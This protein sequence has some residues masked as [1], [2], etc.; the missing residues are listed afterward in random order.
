MKSAHRITLIALA[1]SAALGAGGAA[2]SVFASKPAAAPEVRPALTVNV[3]APQTM[4]LPSR[5]AAHGTVVAWQEASIGAEVSGLRLA[6]VHVNV[7]DVVKRG[8]VLAVY[9]AETPQAELTQLE[10]A[11]AEAEA[12]AADAVAN[13][14]R[15]QTLAT[16]GAMSEQ[17]IAQYLTAE[18]TAAARLKAQ[19][20]AALAQRTRLAKTLVLA[21]DDGVISARSATVGAVANAGQE[22]F[23]LIRAGRLEWRAELTAPEMT[24]VQPGMPA[25]VVAADGSVIDGR[26]RMVA[27]TVDPQTRNGLVYVDLPASAGLK[28]GMF[29][30]GH[31]D[32]GRSTALTV[33]QQA[34][35]TRDGFN[36]VFRLGQGQRVEQ[37]RVNIGR[38]NG[39]RV[40]VVEGIAADAQLVASGA[41][42]LSDGDLV[43]VA[44]SATMA[45]AAASRSSSF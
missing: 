20:S 7:G 34:L 14:Q 33:P 29:A 11:V 40:E 13:A 36:Y 21:P 24:R 43:K 44:G 6:A 12:A 4:D 38:R 45:Q 22:L 16:T 19:R 30:Q 23:R 15:A 39:D 27:P 2:F 18:Q 26:V 17:Q 28:A 1:I 41:G 9:A 8:Q 32:F 25:Q 31:F 3:Q 37:V 5:F 42:F 35:V 10:A